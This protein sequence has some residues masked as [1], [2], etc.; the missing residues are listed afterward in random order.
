MGRWPRAGGKMHS[1]EPLKKGL[2]EREQELVNYALILAN[3]K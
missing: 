1:N 2:N 3:D